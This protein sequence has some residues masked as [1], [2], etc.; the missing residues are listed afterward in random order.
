MKKF[1]QKDLSD[2]AKVVNWACRRAQ[3]I[4]LWI[5]HRFWCRALRCISI[6]GR[7]P[8]EL[9]LRNPH[10]ASEQDS[11]PHLKGHC[12][13]RVDLLENNGSMAVRKHAF[14]ED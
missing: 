3:S 4:Q 8:S 2:A 13:E 7:N 14:F 5:A 9:P 11:S 12:S 1:M 6:N 10:R